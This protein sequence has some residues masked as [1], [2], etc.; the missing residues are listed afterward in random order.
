MIAI[1]DYGVGNLGSI[2]NM[3]KKIGVR[4]IVLAITPGDLE[5]ADKIIL[6]GVGAFDTGM[7]LLKKSGMREELDFQV[8]KSTNLFL[9]YVLECR[10]LGKEAKKAMSQGLVT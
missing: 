7:K 8:K 6:P 10:C 1:I 9:E 5:N 4:E 3:L 2:K